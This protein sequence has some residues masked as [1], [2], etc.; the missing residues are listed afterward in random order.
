MHPVVR[1]NIAIGLLVVLAGGLIVL[2]YFLQRNRKDLQT[3][4]YRAITTDAC[5]IIETADFQNFINSITSDNGLSGELK[6]VKEFANVYG[7]LN[8]IAG[9]LSKPG[10]KRLL[11]GGIA[12]LSFHPS[13]TGKLTPF[14]SMSVPSEIR[15][16][17]VKEIL[18]SI[19]IEDIIE[20]RID[21]TLVLAL[22]YTLNNSNDTLF[23]TTASGLLTCSSSLSLIRGGVSQ[24]GRDTDIRNKPG[25]RRVLSASGKNENKIFIIF[26]NLETAVK[27]LF[28]SNRPDLPGKIASLAGSACGDIFLSDDGLIVSGFAESTGTLDILHR[29][30]LAAH[31]A[32][33]T[34]RILPA[35]VALFET[36]VPGT[37]GVSGAD[38]DPAAGKLT[39][40]AAGIRK[41][42]GDEVT[43]AWF[44]IRGRSAGENTL[45]IYQLNNRVMCEQLLMDMSGPSAPVIWFQPDDQTRFPV[46]QNSGSRL[47]ASIFPAFARGFEEKY[48]TFYDNYLITGNSYITVSRF[49]YDN[50]LNKT[51]ANDLRYRDFESTMPSR[52][53]YLFY[54]VPSDIIDY[55]ALSLSREITEALRS[56]KAVLDKIQAA[57]F[58]FASSNEM[59][60][61]S[62]SV[63]FRDEVRQESLTEW[64]TLLDTVAVIKPFFFTNHNTGAREIFVQDAKNN[65]YLINSA[66]RVLWKVPLRERI[67]GSVYM[68][69]YYRN[70]KF[71][72]LFS[73]REHLHLLDRNGNYVERY[74][75]RLRSPATN[76]LAL[77][78][79]DNNRDY[80]LLIAGEDK[81]IYAYDRT[82]SVVKGWK[83][84]RTTGTVTS[85][86]AF[87]RVS[88]KDY[89]VAADERA[90]Y[91]LDRTGNIRL[92]PGEEVTR[93]AGSA[94]RLNTAGTPSVVCTAPDGTIQH[95]RFDGTVVK[96][97]LREFSDT[98]SFDYFDVDGDSFGEYIYLDQG[99]LYLYN[100]NR[101]EMF[102]REF[103]SADLAGPI[104][105]I[106]SGTDRKIGVVDLNRKLIYLVHRN[107]EIMHGFPLRGASL[108]SIGRLS[109]RNSWH[110]IV[111]GTDRF[112]YNYT[113]E[114]G[115]R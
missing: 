114:T 96:Y 110:L 68:I 25:F 113:L 112:L 81:L 60:Y 73:G 6:K 42:L 69:D 39:A 89:L 106:F 50:M 51:L 86:I 71:Q 65:A 108:F 40:L 21:G 16:R 57:G 37:P 26:E 17:Q 9:Q 7:K 103:G 109:S 46:Y 48:F 93:A 55:L 3:D 83:P 97:R 105:F 33:K 12:L 90:V 88:G 59:I 47:I 102:T 66:G 19:D 5:L 67:N 2:G 80:R 101:T 95:I 98:H 35:S 63:R 34:Y 28:S 62:L 30:R 41:Y 76:P 23:I 49:L 52:A 85:E 56:N 36:I 18:H 115:G 14:L 79:Y 53:G 94:M 32:L 75:V 45:V 15:T 13:E 91:F 82:G 58:Q 27:P 104:N 78:D 72:L 99:K 29:Y 61:N 64:E 111:G 107:G 4:P 20:K 74:P 10:I 22:P 84:F 31:G 100:H 11:G 77:F 44:N 92:R 54:C 70:G 24:Q 43:R 38:T 87:F 1:R 8:Y